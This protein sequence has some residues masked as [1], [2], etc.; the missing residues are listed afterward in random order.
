MK[1]YY[2]V[3]AGILQQS[4]SAGY[5]NPLL[6]PNIPWADAVTGQSYGGPERSLEFVRAS[7]QT[8]HGRISSAWERN[9]V[10]SSVSFEFVIP[11]GTLATIVL[12]IAVPRSNISVEEETTG[13]V[14]Y[15]A[16]PGVAL[17]A[18]NTTVVGSY[19][20]ISFDGVAA[21]HHRLKLRGSEPAVAACTSAGRLSCPSGMVVVSIEQAAFGTQVQT[22]DR[23]LSVC[24]FLTVERCMDREGVTPSDVRR[25]CNRGLLRGQ[26][27]LPHRAGVHREG[28]VRP[29]R[30]RWRF[31]RSDRPAAWEL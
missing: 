17:G 7:M 18:G 12:P 4:D 8:P 20:A 28:C 6:S 3:W 26:R 15:S 16:A 21:G 27:P 24:V 23:P 31:V 10:D 9:R 2:T 22:F 11:N 14:V 1:Y 19:L 25:A 13:S 30:S 29:E 5:A